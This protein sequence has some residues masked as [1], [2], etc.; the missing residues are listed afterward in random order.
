LDFWNLINPYNPDITIGTGPWLGE[1][2]S[3]A[4]VFRDDY[5]GIR[6]ER[7]TRGGGVYFCLKNALHAWNYGGTRIWDGSSGVKSRDT[8]FT[9][10]LTG[11][12]RAP[13]E[14]MRFIERLATRTDSLGKS[15]KRIIIGCDLSLP[16]TKWKVRVDVTIGGQTFKNG[17]V[18]EKGYTKVV[19]G[20]ILGV[21]CWKFP[22][23][24]RKIWLTLAPL[25]KGSM[26]LRG[27]IELE[28]EE[29]YCRSDVERLV[30]VYNK[31]NN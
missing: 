16:Y 25:N 5:T 10:E 23:S 8:K 24:G 9:G 31:I 1:E 30:A 11:I 18:W 17:C 13:N 19:N 2:I 26:I 20:E 15:T 3:N 6:R 28:W 4:E 12:Y 29:N 21:Y 7:N 22:L 14:G 27:I